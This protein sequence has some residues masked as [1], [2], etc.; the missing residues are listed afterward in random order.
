MPDAVQNASTT[1]AADI[2]GSGPVAA[3]VLA[4]SAAIVAGS[5]TYLQSVL[6]RR[7]G[8]LQGVMNT[9]ALPPDYTVNDLALSWNEVQTAA[10]FQESAQTFDYGLAA[11]NGPEA[12]NVTPTRLLNWANALVTNA[13]AYEA[14]LGS[15]LPA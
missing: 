6:N 5:E 2:A 10:Q 1:L 15:S 12:V 3:D 11:L 14:L 8:I 7:I 9:G 13:L 4:L